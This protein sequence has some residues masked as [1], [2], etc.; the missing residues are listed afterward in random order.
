VVGQ[1]DLRLAHRREAWRAEMHAHEREQITR[2]HGERRT[3][4][5]V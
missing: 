5:E 2:A 3:G 4:R 1:P